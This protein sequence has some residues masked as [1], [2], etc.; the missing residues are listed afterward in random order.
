MSL[1]RN[2]LE[3]IRS[4]QTLY[5]VFLFPN[6]YLGITEVILFR[7]TPSGKPIHRNGNKRHL[8]GFLCDRFLNTS[9][10]PYKAKSR[11]DSTSS[12]AL[13]CSFSE[14]DRCCSYSYNRPMSGTIRY[15]STGRY[16]TSYRSVRKH[17]REIMEGLHQ[18]KIMEDASNRFCSRLYFYDNADVD[19]RDINAANLSLMATG[20][21]VFVNSV[22]P[23][24]V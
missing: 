11:K 22:I 6:T 9:T 20:R 5:G 17:A 23:T 21:R 8:R 4:G 15:S 13:G 1:T 12:S 10:I 14:A 19:Q 16:F 18:E 3:K 24:D 2:K 7:D